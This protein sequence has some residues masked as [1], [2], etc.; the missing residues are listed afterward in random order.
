[1]LPPVQNLELTSSVCE[2]DP[3]K[4]SSTFYVAAPTTEPDVPKPA[5]PLPPPRTKRRSFIPKERKKSKSGIITNEEITMETVKS[6]ISKP[7]E[8]I[9]GVETS[10]VT[11]V[12]NGN[13]GETLD[14]SPQDL[15][16]P[17]VAEEA[18]DVC[19]WPKAEG[20]ALSSGEKRHSL[21]HQ[22]EYDRQKSSDSLLKNDSEA[23]G[24]MEVD[25]VKLRG[26]RRNSRKFSI[27]CKS[28]LIDLRDENDSIT[29]PVG[30]IF[31]KSINTRAAAISPK[32]RDAY[33]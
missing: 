20:A 6:K 25:G 9:L 4:I 28:K 14:T 32:L 5:A 12:E 17:D 7:E 29:S 26:L 24:T 15:V 1:M 27:K 11:G 22:K 3:T 2:I 10:T 13:G 19:Y 18:I 8:E 21:Q 16:S 30:K 31:R 23:P 33:R